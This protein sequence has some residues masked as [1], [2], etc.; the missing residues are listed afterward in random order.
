[1]ARKKSKE[2]LNLDNVELDEKWLYELATLYN[3][4][5]MSDLCVRTCGKQR[6]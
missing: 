4:V 6:E 1:M 5:G 3:E 2:E